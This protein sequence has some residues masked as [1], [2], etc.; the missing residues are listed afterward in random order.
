MHSGGVCRGGYV[1][2]AVGIGDR[3]HMTGDM[4]HI[5]SEIGLVT[6]YT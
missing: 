1:P 3:G 4:C 6:F 2:V 5:T